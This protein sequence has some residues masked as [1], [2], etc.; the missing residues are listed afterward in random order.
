MRKV[1]A[2]LTSVLML[3]RPKVLE[4]GLLS[5]YSLTL[6]TLRCISLW[7]YPKSTTTGREGDPEIQIGELQRFVLFSRLSDDSKKH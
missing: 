5:A 2:S 7:P 1:W 3:L 6:C 4:E